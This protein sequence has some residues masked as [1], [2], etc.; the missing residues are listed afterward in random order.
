MLD[1]NHPAGRKAAA[2]AGAVNF[3]DY[4]NGRVAGANEIGVHAVTGAIFDCAV[5]CHHCLRDH[6]AA[7][8]ALRR[9]SAATNAAKQVLLQTF[10]IKEGHQIG[11]VYHKVRL[12]LD[13]PST[14]RISAMSERPL[15]PLGRLHATLT[16]LAHRLWAALWSGM[17]KL[18]DT[19]W[20]NHGLAQL[21]AHGAGALKA[22]RLAKSLNVSRGSF[23]WHFADIAAY[24]A[25]LLDLWAARATHAMVAHLDRRGGGGDR[26][27]K[28]LSLA[29][30]ASPAL[31]RAVRSWATHD[32]A[33]AKAVRGVDAVRLRYLREGLVSAG[34]S[35]DV[36]G[37]RAS[38]IYLAYVGR[39]MTDGPAAVIDERAIRYVADLMSA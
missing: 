7:I 3:I 20:L 15:G 29:M 10:N 22:D 2:I 9:F 36:A 8:D 1:R 13:C 28:L 34:I 21:A 19:D 33:A 4:G 18:S 30:R 38:L 24:R 32:E 25:R 35:V 27:G 39:V 23:Y 37:A 11:M 31:E 5:R 14:S 6:M 17:M 12:F 16:N 26:L